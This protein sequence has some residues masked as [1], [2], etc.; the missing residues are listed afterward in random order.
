MAPAAVQ[1]TWSVSVRS[2]RKSE[3]SQAENGPK[4]RKRR[5]AGA[6]NTCHVW[7]EDTSATWLKQVQETRE[8][9]LVSWPESPRQSEVR[10]PPFER[11]DPR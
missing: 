9:A 4:E 6:L 7:A 11:A 2:G 10:G 3:E 8:P 5:M 1:S